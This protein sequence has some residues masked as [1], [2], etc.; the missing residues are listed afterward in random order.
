[1]FLTEVEVELCHLMK[2]K[3]APYTI[4]VDSVTKIE[5][6]NNWLYKNTKWSPRNHFKI[7]CYLGHLEFTSRNSSEVNS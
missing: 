6:R 2:R 3:A 4:Q 7:H 5:S 1:M